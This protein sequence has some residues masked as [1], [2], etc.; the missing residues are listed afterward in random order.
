[1]ENQLT[2]RIEIILGFGIVPM[3]PGKTIESQYRTV[4]NLQCLNTLCVLAVLYIS[5]I[6]CM[7]I[8]EFGNA[9]VSW[10]ALAIP[11]AI[12]FTLILQ[13]PQSFAD[14][15]LKRHMIE[16]HNKKPVQKNSFNRDLKNVLE[17]IEDKKNSFKLL[18]P[19]VIL[20]IAALLKIAYLNPIWIVFAYITPICAILV[21]AKTIMNYRAVKKCITRFEK[22]AKQ[23][24]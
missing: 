3:R 17:K 6:A 7:T 10:D 5:T 9:G 1:M 14:L 21:F 20:I 22:Q 4:K 8:F 15:F 11:V 13:L 23:N 12:S 18:F 2:P 24:S 19:T 16:L